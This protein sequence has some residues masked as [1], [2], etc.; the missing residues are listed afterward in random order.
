MFLSSIRSSIHPRH[1]PTHPSFYP[2][3]QPPV[4]WTSDSSIFRCHHGF[5]KVT[6]PLKRF[7]QTPKINR[8]SRLFGCLVRW[9]M[10]PQLKASIAIWHS[11][12]FTCCN[13]HSW[14][15]QGILNV[16]TGRHHMACQRQIYL[17]FFTRSKLFQPLDLLP[18]VWSVIWIARP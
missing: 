17:P 8:F 7:W 11:Y 14:A 1:P 15:L 3:I 2:I 13:R 5:H 18:P 6:N 9:I 16:F 12:L 10:L 4:Y